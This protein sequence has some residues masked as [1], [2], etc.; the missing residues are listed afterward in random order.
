LNIC[1]QEARAEKDDVVGMWMWPHAQ[2][3]GYITAGRANNCE[4]D[5][6]TQDMVDSI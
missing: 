2:D 6:A 1:A 3:V 5:R 4:A